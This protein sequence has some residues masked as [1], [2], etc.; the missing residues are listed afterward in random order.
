MNQQ[1]IF[2]ITTDTFLT[3][4]PI[5]QL[6]HFFTK[7]FT[8]ASSQIYIE[9]NEDFFLKTQFRNKTIVFK[10]YASYKKQSIA[11]KY[12]K[13]I[14][15]LNY[16]FFK[17]KKIK[18]KNKNVVYYTI[19]LFTLYVAT[20][21]KGKH[22]KLIYHQF[23]T[24]EINSMN[25]LD[26]LL[27]KRITNRLSKI[28]III[29]PEANRIEIF[30]QQINCT[31]NKKFFLLPNTNNRDVDEQVNVKESGKIIVAHIGS[32]GNNSNIISYIEAIKKMNTDKYEFWFVGRLLPNIISTINEMNF[33]NIKLINQVPHNELDRIYK[34]ID[35]GI[36]LYDNSSVNL[37]YC[38]PNK[39]YEYWSYGIPVI[40]D[41]LPG[42]ASVF[43]NDLQGRLIDMSNVDAFVETILEL[44]KGSYK[45]RSSLL[46]LFSK[47]Y[48][49]SN[50][51]DKLLS[52]LKTN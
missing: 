19:D 49:L 1:L 17:V 42:L 30:K 52:E 15:T 38:A 14:K 48:R 34:M 2:F 35:I 50:Y 44:S 23:E 12:L 25:K 39:L 36:I 31:D 24:L 11:N 47:E 21:I 20:F 22:D 9:E 40:G 33:K 29:L 18:H 26:K 32:V 8:I 27:I 37:R 13:Y 28:D 10:D 51:Y 7:D 3:L 4:P 5:K 46:Q 45:N 16:L 43:N 6:L 41:I